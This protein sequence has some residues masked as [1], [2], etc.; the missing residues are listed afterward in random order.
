LAYAPAWRESA[1][2]SLPGGARP[3]Y[4]QAQRLARNAHPE[5]I[6][7]GDFASF[8]SRNDSPYQSPK[9]SA[10]DARFS[11]TPC[12]AGVLKSRSIGASSARDAVF[13]KFLEQEPR[14][15]RLIMP[16][17]V[18]LLQKISGDTDETHAPEFLDG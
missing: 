14:Q 16:D 12:R 4:E 15:T 5:C 13:D 6:Q 8:G 11:Q 1:F 17:D 7:L 9:C 3:V 2:Q 10:T 18:V